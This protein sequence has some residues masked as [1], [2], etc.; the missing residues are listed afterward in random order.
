[1]GTGNYCLF[2]STWSDS[3][4]EFKM[5]KSNPLGREL[6]ED[7]VYTCV[8]E[9]RARR[10]QPACPVNMVSVHGFRARHVQPACP[11]NVVSLLESMR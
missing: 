4:S 2:M 6:L 5:D 7:A 8:H 9:L 1:M 11:V 10:V 3:K